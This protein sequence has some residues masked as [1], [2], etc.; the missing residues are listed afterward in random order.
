MLK[1]AHLKALACIRGVAGRRQRPGVLA[2]ALP[3]TR[4]DFDQGP[5]PLRVS[6]PSAVTW[7]HEDKQSLESVP[8]KTPQF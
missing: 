1:D 7:R 6:A 8:M 5:P 2:S 4:G 3:L